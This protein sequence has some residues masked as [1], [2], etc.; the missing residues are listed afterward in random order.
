MLSKAVLSSSLGLSSRLMALSSLQIHSTAHLANSNLPELPKRPMSAFLRFSA[1]KREEIVRS[2]G[3]VNVKD[4]A[5]KCGEMW[6]DLSEHE[7]ER[8]VSAYRKDM[9]DWSAKTE[10]VREHLQ[11][12]N[13]LDDI[14]AKKT[15]ERIAKRL[16]RAKADLKKLYQN[17]GMPKRPPHALSLFCKERLLN[18]GRKNDFAEICQEWAN[19]DERGKSR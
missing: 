13:L 3:M 6:K 14:E 5:K 15:E 4:V 11:K 1:E 12:A 10:S 2:S 17:L 19:L 18:S 7:K 16:K 8:Y 9:A